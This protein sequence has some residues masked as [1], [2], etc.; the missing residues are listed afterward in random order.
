MIAG[1]RRAAPLNGHDAFPYGVVYTHRAGS[2]RLFIHQ[3]VAG[4]T[5]SQA[6]AK[7]CA[8]QTKIVT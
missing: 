6:T 2:D 3:N 4:P 1:I 8:G 7:A 5:D